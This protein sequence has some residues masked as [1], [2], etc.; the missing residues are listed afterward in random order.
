MLP[1]L[2]ILQDLSHEHSLKS[3]KLIQLLNVFKGI[4]DL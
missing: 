2:K 1:V 4:L 3:F